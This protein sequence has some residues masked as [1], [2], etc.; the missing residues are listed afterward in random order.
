LQEPAG[1][2]AALRCL[3][4]H[5]PHRDQPSYINQHGLLMTMLTLPVIHHIASADYAAALMV[6]LQMAYGCCT[7]LLCRQPAA[8]AMEAHDVFQ[9]LKFVLQ[10]R[11]TRRS[12]WSVRQ[13]W[14]QDAELLL[15]LPA[16]QQLDALQ[17][18]ELLESAS[19]PECNRWDQ[20]A[21]P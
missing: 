7:E 14:V 4:Q 16:V 8:R 9:L 10:N 3:L 1:L 21:Q 11:L 15:A 13:I 20:A 19:Y 2:A 12:G 18:A 17:I 5:Q 6:P